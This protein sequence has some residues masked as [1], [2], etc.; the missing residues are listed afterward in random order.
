MGKVC[1]PSGK[2]LHF[3]RIHPAR[4]QSELHVDLLMFA[5][6]KWIRFS[7]R[8]EQRA[9]GQLYSCR[10]GWCA[11]PTLSSYAINFGFS[12][13]VVICNGWMD[14]ACI[15]WGKCSEGLFTEAPES[16]GRTGFN[17]SS[18]TELAMWLQGMLQGLP[19]TPLQDW[20]LGPSF[21][22]GWLSM[23]L[24]LSGACSASDQPFPGQS[25]SDDW[26]VYI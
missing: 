23:A 9:Q 12:A 6:D 4:A 25:A 15:T 10:T 8:E 16:N 2:V 18:G 20:V 19:R 26:L 21:W 13:L 5:N 22:K 24:S 1:E 17:L 3:P 11:D 7:P 14:R